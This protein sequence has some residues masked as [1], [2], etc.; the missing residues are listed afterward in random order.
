MKSVQDKM[1]PIQI[2][3]VAIALSIALGS[4]AGSC[5]THRSAEEPKV[6]AASHS[7]RRMPDGKEW[8]TENLNVTTERSYCYEDAES[9]CRRYGRLYT[10]E[11]AQRGCRSLGDGWRLPTNDEWRQMAKHYGGVRDDSDDGGKAAYQA[12]SIGGSSGFNALFGGR[13]DPGDGQYA[14]LEAHGFYWTASE[15]DSAS[16]WFYN[17]GRGG[18]IL[19]RHSDGEK[20]RALSVRCVRD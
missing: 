16:A 1:T 4:V 5:S 17:L 9:N 12:L 20:Q 11:S 13:R 10:W 15:S 3:A 14:R 18:L 19:N 2:R 7:F 8:M 6:P